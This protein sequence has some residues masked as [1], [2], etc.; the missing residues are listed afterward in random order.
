MFS[1]HFVDLFCVCYFF[2]LVF[3]SKFCQSDISK[4]SWSPMLDIAEALLN[5]ADRR[6]EC[7]DCIAFL[8]SKAHV[9]GTFSKIFFFPVFLN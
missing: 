4:V 1:I 2:S 3:V 7:E 5:V 6:S 8:A 9:S